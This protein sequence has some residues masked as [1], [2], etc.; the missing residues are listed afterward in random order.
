[1]VFSF[2]SFFWEWNLNLTVEVHPFV[3]KMLLITDLERY[4]DFSDRM[5][6][7]NGSGWVCAG[8]MR[9]IQ[10]YWLC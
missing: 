9:D 3:D 5:N 2:P 6:S 1:M 8:I 7:K 4:Y 10:L